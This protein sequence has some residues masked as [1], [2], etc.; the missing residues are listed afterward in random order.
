MLNHFAF[1]QAKLIHDAGN[2]L[3]HK[4]AH[5]IVFE[6][7]V[8]LRST[9]IT[10]T[11]G[12]S[13]QLSVYTAW[14]VALG[15]NDS[16]ASGCFWFWCQLDIRSTTRHVCGNGY[17][18]RLARFSYNLGFALM[19]L[20]IQ[21]VVFDFFHLQHAADQL[22]NFNRC[23]TYQNRSS[24]FCKFHDLFNGCI[25]FFTHRF[26]NKV[27]R[28]VPGDGAIGRNHNNIQFIDVP[29]FTG[30][31]FCCT[32]HARKLVV[33]AEIILKGNGGIGLC[34]ILHLHIFFR[35]YRLV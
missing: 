25:E 1:F 4:E 9:R 21:Y 32:C 7:N 35:F 12:T 14:L 2:A 17:G 10:L 31:C 29:Q 8:K 27:V 11:S 19:L 20:C 18:T 16:K 6:R 28:I 24:F 5:Q 26:E 34:G 13:A 3:R 33:H 15:T 22:W 30:F 23:G